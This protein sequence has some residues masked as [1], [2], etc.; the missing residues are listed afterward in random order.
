VVTTFWRRLDV[1]LPDRSGVEACR[2]ILSE[3]PDMAVLM[4]TSFSDDQALF[5]S[6]MAGAAD[7][8]RVADR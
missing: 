7:T 5:N 6:I 4:L 3:H 8:D 2:D 1:R